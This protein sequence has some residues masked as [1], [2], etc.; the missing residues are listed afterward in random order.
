MWKIYLMVIVFVVSFIAE[1]QFLG[2]VALRQRKNPV[3]AW[4]PG[5]SFLFIRHLAGKKTRIWWII[6]LLLGG[7][8]CYLLG[9]NITVFVIKQT[10]IWAIFIWYWSAFY[11]LMERETDLGLGWMTAA[12][13]FEP[14][15][16]YIMHK[17]AKKNKK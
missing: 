9:D 4:I 11:T 17:M 16:L 8:I 14:A 1:S 13:F 5:I 3:L 2:K 15:K 7:L 10:L 6:G 12:I